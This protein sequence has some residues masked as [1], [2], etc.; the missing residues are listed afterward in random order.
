MGSALN[1]VSPNDHSAVTTYGS[2]VGND[3]HAVTHDEDTEFV[4]F[5]SA[6]QIKTCD[7]SMFKSNSWKNSFLKIFTG[8]IPYLPV[9]VSN[10]GGSRKNSSSQD[11]EQE[12]DNS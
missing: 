2:D 1:D 9:P 6:T 5:Y 10:E 7:R 12:K 3:F 11:K 4:S 8:K